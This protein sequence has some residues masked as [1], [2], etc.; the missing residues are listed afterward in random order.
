[1]VACKNEKLEERKEKQNLLFET[2]GE[3]ILCG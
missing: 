2:G 1:M 3:K